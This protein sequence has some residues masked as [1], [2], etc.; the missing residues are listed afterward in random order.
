MAASGKIQRGMERQLQQWRSALAGG[1]GRLGWK[2]G[3]NRAADQQKFDL[4]S[5]MIGYLTQRRRIV[6]GGSYAVSTESAILA[7]PEIALL[8]GCDV[9]PGSSLADAR[10]AIAAWAPALELVDTTRTHSSDIEEILAGNLFHEAVVIGTAVADCT[11]EFDV[12][13]KVDG[14]PV[15]TLEADRLPTDFATLICVVA[16]LLGQQGER[17]QAGDWII[18]GAAATPVE[19]HPGAKIELDLLPLGQLVLTTTGV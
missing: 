2:I 17:L 13:L 5:P 8:L 7:E 19:L 12:T 14:E 16:E 18:T 4:P 1:E 10:N 11:G 9:A 3:F 6:A 15:R